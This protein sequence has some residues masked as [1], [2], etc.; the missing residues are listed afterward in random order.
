[1]VFKRKIHKRKSYKRKS[2]KRRIHK[3]G[4]TSEC[5]KDCTKCNIKD[6]CNLRAKDCTWSPINVTEKRLAKLSD[7]IIKINPSFK[8]AREYN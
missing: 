4:M 7:K 6:D 2:Y 1:M 8:Y 3:G 5:R